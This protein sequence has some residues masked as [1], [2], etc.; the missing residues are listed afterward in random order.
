MC[1]ECY[2]R[3]PNDVKIPNVIV[4][5]RKLAVDKG[6]APKL[7]LEVKKNILESSNVFNLDNETKELTLE[8]IREKLALKGMYLPTKPKAKVVYFPGCLSLYLNRVQ[9]IAYSIIAILN[10]AKENWTFLEDLK[11]CGYP[12][13][14][15][16]TVSED[17]LRKIAEWNVALI[18]RSSAKLLVTGC[19]GCLRAFKEEY[20][21]LL[22][23]E[24]NFEVVHFVQLLNKYLDRKRIPRPRKLVERATYHDPCELGRVCGVFDEARELLQKKK[25][26]SRFVE[27]EECLRN[28]RCCGA[29]GFLR[30]THEALSSALANER[31]KTLIKTRAGLC[32]TAC[33]S[34]KLNLV[35]AASRNNDVMKIMDIAELVAQQLKLL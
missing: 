30:S 6:A 27:S 23:R 5:L 18:E 26:V 3:C 12:L 1:Y 20:P 32:I 24:L 8:A 33:P 10:K 2:D 22:G 7:V 31:L 34:C 4:A 28:S 29:G 35:D 25:L 21:K 15:T 14:L 11:C 16:G 9:G 17:T 19:P 13:L